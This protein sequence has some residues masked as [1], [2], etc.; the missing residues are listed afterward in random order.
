M[1]NQK[2]KYS[3]KTYNLHDYTRNPTRLL[4]VRTTLGL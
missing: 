4:A 2:N 3:L 1:G